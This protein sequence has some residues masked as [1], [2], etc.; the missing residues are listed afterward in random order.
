MAEKTVTFL[1]EVEIQEISS[2]ESVQVVPSP[3]NAPV[4]G[5]IE[6]TSLHQEIIAAVHPGWSYL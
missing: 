2:N 3:A 5:E 1:P 4:S 6:R